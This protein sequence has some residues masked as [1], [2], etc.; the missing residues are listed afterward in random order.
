MKFRR[1]TSA[2]LAAAIFATGTSITAFA[3]QDAEMTKALTYVKQRIS[4]PEELTEFTHSTRLV[5]NKTQYQFMW[6]TANDYEGSPA[7]LTITI[8]GKVIT[9][10]EYYNSEMDEPDVEV[11]EDGIEISSN[12]PSFA[13]L[14]KAQLIAKAKAAIKKLNPTVY[15]N[16]TIDE[17]NFSIALNSNEAW[18]TLRRTND[19]IPV[20]GQNGWIAINK[21]TG[22]LIYYYM[23][24]VIGAGFAD[25]DKAVS[26]EKAQQGFEENFPV[27]LVYNASYDWQTKTYTPYLMYRQ[28]RFGQIDALT[29]ELSTFQ[30]SYYDYGSS[31]DEVEDDAVDE[32]FDEDNLATGAGE[33]KVTF[34]DKEKEQLEKEGKLIKAE[35]ALTALKKGGIFH[36]PEGSEISSSS[37]F[38]NEKLGFYVRSASFNTKKYSEAGS[39][40]IPVYTTDEEIAVEDDDG[41]SYVYYGNFTINAETGR[42]LSF[43]CSDVNNGKS[44]SQT[45][46]TAAVKK[47]LNKLLGD[48][49]E[50][51]EIDGVDLNQFYKSY[52]PKT[53]KG[54]GNPLNRSISYSI[55]RTIDGIK[56]LVEGINLT[57]GNSGKIT[58]YNLTDYG[59]QYPKAENIISES[60]AYDKF[61]EQVDYDLQYRCAYNATTK[62][63]TTAMVYNADKSL[64]IDAF[65]GKLTNSDGSPYIVTEKTTAYTDIEG[66]KYRKYAEKL[67]EYGIYIGDENGKLNE[68]K[69]ITYDDFRNL[70]SYAGIYCPYDSAIKGTTAVTRQLA[71]KMMTAGIVGNDRVMSIKGIF[72]SPFTD[73]SEDSAYV[74][75]IAVAKVAGLMDC[76]M[77]K[78]T[79]SPKAKLSRGTA[80][81]IIYDYLSK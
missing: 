10:Y 58:S 49:A 2:A 31:A 78:S 23:D 61:F 54:I 26:V 19:G 22:E 17:D 44:L 40:D 51:F 30:N 29:G 6:K 46:T 45:K 11:D 73:V 38:Y 37:C 20:A 65:T 69:A 48:D 75:Y 63:V 70:L 27:M 43:Y 14:T 74:G 28:V 9:S 7:N 72:K 81:R 62:K 71:A 47:W 16:I 5:N 39:F 34:T 18:V 80:L 3:E 76:I 42:V 13:K 60:E 15:E 56:S 4:I 21:N 32:D 33:N 36:V 24:W 52:D 68:S 8:T 50:K 25:K 35:D 53:G 59:I 64:Y 41:S 12:K 66:S 55:P 79:F 57:V 1:V 67:A 77:S